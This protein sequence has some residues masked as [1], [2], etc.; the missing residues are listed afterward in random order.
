ML[1][2]LNHPHDAS[3]P[4]ITTTIH[5]YTIHRI[6]ILPFKVPIRKYYKQTTKCEAFVTYT[7]NKKRT[8]TP[9]FVVVVGAQGAIHKNI[10]HI[11]NNQVHV[12]INLRLV[13]K[14]ST[15]SHTH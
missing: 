3:H 7:T 12:K 8:V 11:L 1:L 10:K 9:L 14:Q 2:L 13:N 6:Y 4:N 5:H 15:K